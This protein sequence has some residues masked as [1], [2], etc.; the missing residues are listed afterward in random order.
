MWAMPRVI[1]NRILGHA[2]RCA[3]EECVGILSGHGRTI[4][5]WH[6]LTNTLHDSQRFLADPGEQITLFK[7]LREQGAELVAIYHSHP[8]GSGQPSI[9]DREE[10]H[11][12][13]ALHLIVALGTDGR[14]E[15]NG[16]LL[17]DGRFQPQELSV[18]D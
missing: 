12:P 8:V 7:Q 9:L 10:N 1:V 6:P 15:L 13:N 4:A 17:I 16:F 3:P 2:Q 11:Y 5:G 14:L 18:T